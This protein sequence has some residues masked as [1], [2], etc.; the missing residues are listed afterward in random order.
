MVPLRR[1]ALLLFALA[2]A[3]AGAQEPVQVTTVLQVPHGKKPTLTVKALTRVSNVVLE[4]TRDGEESAK[5]TT[6]RIGSLNAGQSRTLPI[7]DGAIGSATY[8]GTLSLTWG[9]GEAW[10]GGVN[11]ATVVNAEI[12]IGYQREHLFLDKHVLEFQ[13][14]RASAELEADLTVY[15]DEGQVIGDGKQTFTKVQPGKWIAIPW[16]PTDDS[17][18]MMMKL[19]VSDPGGFVDET[20]TPWQVSIPHEEVNFATN[21][22]VIEPSERPKVDAAYDAILAEVNKAQKLGVRCNLFIAGHTD[23][24][25]P[26][27]KNQKLSLDRAKSIATYFRKRGLSIKVSY[28]GFGEERLKVATPDETDERANRRADYTLSAEG[29]PSAG[30][31]FKWKEVK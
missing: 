26:R 13:I 19:H 9:A 12:K 22:A 31:T 16:Q 15:G 25:G 3:R 30:T 28:E 24:V 10:S 6:V 20:L 7:G 27:D 11:M 1:A 29:P 17:T 2:A 21:S 14:S 8:S 5:P 18:V 23:T 4:L